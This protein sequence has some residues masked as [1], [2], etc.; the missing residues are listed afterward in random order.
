LASGD[1]IIRIAGRLVI[2]HRHAVATREK[3]LGQ[4][5]SNKSGSA[6]N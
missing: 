4:M 2:D 3:R 6:G 5:R 1:K